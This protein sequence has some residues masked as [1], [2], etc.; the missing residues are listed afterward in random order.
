MLV[1]FRI[2]IF[3]FGFSPAEKHNEN[4]MISENKNLKEPP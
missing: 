3:A 1:G 2:N 4:K